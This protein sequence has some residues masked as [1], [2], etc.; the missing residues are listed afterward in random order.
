MKYS[1]FLVFCSLSFLSACTMDPDYSRLGDGIFARVETP[2]GE[3]FIKFEDEKAPL[4]VANFIGLTDGTI[5]NKIK[6]P[7]EPYFDGMTFHRVEPNILIQGGDPL[8]NGL[9]GP[10]YKFSQEIHPDLTHNEPGTV[11]M[12]NAGPGTNG[13]QWY[14]TMVPLPQL[15]GGYN[16]FGFVVEGLD[17]VKKIQRNDPMIKVEIIRNGEAA[18]NFDETKVFI[19]HP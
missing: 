19:K 4:S 6:G 10:G 12:A 14:V 15:N 13:S 18:Q 2:H 1:L 17:I 5:D 9:G 3:F 11:A 8:A 16:I 7:G